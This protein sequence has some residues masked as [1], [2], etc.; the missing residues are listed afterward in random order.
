MGTAQVAL[1]V[2]GGP[3]AGHVRVSRRVMNGWSPP[4]KRRGIGK[5]CVPVGHVWIVGHADYQMLHVQWGRKWAFQ[6]EQG[7]ERVMPSLQTR[8]CKW[9]V[10]SLTV[11]HLWENGCRSG[12]GIVFR[13]RKYWISMRFYWKLQNSLVFWRILRAFS[14]KKA[15]PVL[16]VPFWGNCCFVVCIS[17]LE[18]WMFFCFFPTRASNIAFLWQSF[19][20]FGTCKKKTC[21]FRFKTLPSYDSCAQMMLKS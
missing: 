8:S 20:C 1:H 10:A 6:N 3:L 15:H 17:G 21:A 5:P 18:K 12:F 2:L 13:S 4:C 16:E 7:H 9:G 19:A 14:I 11:L